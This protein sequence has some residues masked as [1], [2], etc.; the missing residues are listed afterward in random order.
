MGLGPSNLLESGRVWIL[1]VI[2]PISIDFYVAGM[3]AVSM[4][5]FMFEH[6]YKQ[7][8]LGNSSEG[9]EG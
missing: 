5:L 6:L 3:G 8:K 2:Y 9:G 7:T 4:T 1:R